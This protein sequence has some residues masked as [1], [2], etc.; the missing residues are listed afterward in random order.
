MP[1]DED[2][3]LPPGLIADLKRHDARPR[4][5]TAAL[6]AEVAALTDRHFRGAAR[7]NPGRL[8]ATGLAAA[9]VMGLIVWL[10]QPPAPIAAPPAAALPHDF[11]TDGQVDILDAMVLARHLDTPNA[12]NPSGLISGGGGDVNGDGVTDRRDV[13]ALGRAVVRVAPRKDGEA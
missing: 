2:P 1:S 7:G 11:N 5:D 10:G 6:D 9:A 8:A 13:D 4:P 3:Q 12:G